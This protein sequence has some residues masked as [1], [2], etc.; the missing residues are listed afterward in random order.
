M[1]IAK[2]QFI[3]RYIE[4]LSHKVRTELNEHIGEGQFFSD[5]IREANAIVHSLTKEE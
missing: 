3:E 5:M 2:E 1:I 4:R